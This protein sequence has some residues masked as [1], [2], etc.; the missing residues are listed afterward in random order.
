MAA[1]LPT[2]SA[3]LRHLH[4]D[5]ILLSVLNRIKADLEDR[6]IG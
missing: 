1:R 3:R 2:T 4:R 5:L 6:R